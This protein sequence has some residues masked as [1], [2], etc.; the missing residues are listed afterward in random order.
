MNKMYN[1]KDIYDQ[2]EDLYM[3]IRRKKISEINEQIL[4]EEIRNIV[5]RERLLLNHFLMP[6]KYNEFIGRSIKIISNSSE[7]MQFNVSLQLLRGILYG[8]AIV[9]KGE[10][11]AHLLASLEQLNLRNLY[12]D[13]LC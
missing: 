7:A 9:N 13:E 12:F 3:N 6:E 8:I 1:F 10:Q 11:F 2:L 4:F 5:T